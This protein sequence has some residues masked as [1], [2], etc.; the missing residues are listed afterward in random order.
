[1]AFTL[2][3]APQSTCSQRVRFVLNAKGLAFE[4]RKLDLLAGD[5]LDPEY[6]VLN[7]N[8]VVPTLVHDGEVVIDSSVIIEYLDEIAPARE[9]FTP[10]APAERARMR[11]LMRFIDEVPAAAV[12]VPTYNLAFLPRFAAMSEPDFLALAVSKP[13]RKEFMLA[14]GRT[15][16]PDQE[17]DA[18][19]DRMRQT[20]RRMEASIAR[21]GGPFL[22]GRQPTL[23]DVSVMPAIV[24]MDDLGLA[25][26]WADKPAIGRWYDAIRAHPAFGPT[27][28][29]GSL[30][31]DLFP[32]LRDNRGGRAPAGA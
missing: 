4:E 15:G 28:Y 20:Y 6:L 19:L 8:G 10:Q 13:L 5:Q 7:P 21:S 25:A 12:R 14:M 17:M 22:Q 27:Y 16:F 11:S 29:P 9:S 31:T 3:N 1:M 23:A 2:Y 32:H 30:L 24:R 26:M 18:A